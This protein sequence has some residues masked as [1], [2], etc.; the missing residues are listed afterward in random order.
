[1]R[2]LT[3]TIGLS[4]V[5][6]STAAFAGAGSDWGYQGETGPAKWG[7]LKPENKICDEGKLQSPFDIS[8][9][10]AAAE[11]P[12][13]DIAYK[14]M[15]LELS[16]SAN[17]VTV[18]AAAGSTMT[19]GKDVY[20]LLQFHF[21]TPSEY[22]I[23]GKSFPMAL[24]L[25]H[26]R[27]SDGALGVLGVMIEE[28]AENAVLAPIW[29]HIPKP[30]EKAAPKDMTVDASGLLPEKRDY[31]RFM[32]S[33]TTPPCSEGV[34]WHMMSTPIQASKEQIAAFTKLFGNTARPLQPANNRL[35]ISE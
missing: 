20:E 11:L 23:E 22:H 29:K 7:S 32:G 16:S 26:K 25:V 18:A 14:A 13:L 27:A 33:L 12:K 9:T 6:L 34:N 19:V 2:I 10:F 21:H 24:H 30:G 28:G 5:M 1:M 15:P 31:M 3:A 35:V 8:A 17:G 4:A